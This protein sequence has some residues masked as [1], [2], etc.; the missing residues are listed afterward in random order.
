MSRGKTLLAA[1][2]LGALT[3]C[4]GGD[5]SLEPDEGAGLSD[6]LVPIADQ[7][8]LPDTTPPAPPDTVFVERPSPP[9]VVTR[10]PAARPSPPP[11]AAPAPP[12]APAP[13]PVLRTLASGTEIG[14]TTVDSI[15]SRYNK[16]G[17]AVQVTVNRNIIDTAGRTVIPAGSVITLGIV[18]IAPAASKGG[19]GTLVLAARSVTIDGVSHPLTA[20]ATDFEYEL[21]GRGVTGREV[22]KTG[23]GA[24]GGAII[25]RVIGGKTGTIVGAIGGAAAGAAV[26]DASQDRDVVVTAGKTIV[27]TLR[28]DFTPGGEG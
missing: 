4:G 9:P 19:T 14:T 1:M 23:A 24:V 10:P 22:A 28:D 18:E 11:A 17:D 6:S 12:P 13:A 16:V 21:R 20:R 7:P 5:A 25:G 8:L 26:A 2:V 3:A 15:H 27:L